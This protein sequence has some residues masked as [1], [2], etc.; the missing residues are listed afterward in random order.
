MLVTRVD[1]KKALECG[2]VVADETTRE[3]LHYAERPQACVSDLVNM[4][5]YVFAPALFDVIAQVIAV[6]AQA[7]SRCVRLLYAYCHLLPRR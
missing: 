1:A 6:N 7:A 2:E 4:G 5:I 3:L